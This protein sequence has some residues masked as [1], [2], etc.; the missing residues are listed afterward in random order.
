MLH[1]ETTYETGRLW[2]E[3]IR[4]AHAVE[5]F[6]LLSD[7]RLYRFIPQD[8][9]ASLLAVMQRYTRLESRRSPCGRELWLNWVLRSKLGRDCLGT[10]QATVRPDGS[11]YFAYEL[12]AAF[13]GNGFAT[14]AC[15]RIV[16]ALFEDFDSHTIEAEVDTRN[17]RSIGL[18]E[19]LGFQRTGMRIGA[20]HFKDAASDEYRY[21]LSRPAVD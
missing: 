15:G 1:T 12:G 7:D 20:D 5:L 18:L 6:E 19:R 13:W 2:L 3:P 14:E 4:G 17:L 21:V 11:S 9:P 10:V 8:P 16:L